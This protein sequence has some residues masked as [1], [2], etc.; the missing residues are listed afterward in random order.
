MTISSNWRGRIS[1]A[2]GAAVMLGAS[3]AL[4]TIPDS[5]GVIHGCYTKSTGTIRVIDNSVTNCKSGE[6]SLQWNVQGRQGP[7]GLPGAQGPA[8][9]QG[10]PGATG[11]PGSAGNPGPAG[12]PGP[13]GPAGISKADFAGTAKPL[14]LP[15]NV[16]TF[17]V[18]KA[19][20]PGSWVFVATVNGVGPTGRLFEG[21]PI[22]VVTRCESRDETGAPLGSPAVATGL[23]SQEATVNTTLTLTGGTFVSDSQAGKNI[24]IWCRVSGGE[25]SNPHNCW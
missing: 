25:D 4:A 20:T 10:T 24:E 17:V 1:I 14:T 2:T 15:D 11:A 3:I 19:V 16:F 8:G 12:A 6:T 7:Q 5:S 18:R 22:E 9:A 23:K 21:D 13:A